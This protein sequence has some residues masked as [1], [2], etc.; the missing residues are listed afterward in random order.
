M[1][2][3]LLSVERQEDIFHLNK[4]GFSHRK[5]ASFLKIPRSTVGKVIRTGDFIKEKSVPKLPPNKWITKHD[6]RRI[7]NLVKITKRKIT[8]KKITND[9]NLDIS[10]RQTRRIL[11]KNGYKK[12]KLKKKPILNKIHKEKRVIFA[13]IIF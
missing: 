7:K 8:S 1:K 3:K 11:N 2:G 12:T 13:K 10:S 5:I 9:L 4:S 6:E